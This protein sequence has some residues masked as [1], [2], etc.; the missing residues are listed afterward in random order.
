MRLPLSWL[1]GDVG[2]QPCEAGVGWEFRG[3]RSGTHTP[4]L[5]G[6]AIVAAIGSSSSDFPVEQ[7]YFCLDTQSVSSVATTEAAGYLG[8]SIR[9]ESEVAR[10]S[11]GDLLGSSLSLWELAFFP[12][13]ALTS[14]SACFGSKIV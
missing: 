14:N 5:K 6:E 1:R 4:P 12:S 3:I 7:G 10:A 2:I 9:S 13:Y 8:R 11:F